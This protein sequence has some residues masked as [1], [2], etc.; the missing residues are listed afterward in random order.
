MSAP[1]PAKGPPQRVALDGRYARLE[2]LRRTHADDLFAA[3]SV[4]D[5]AQR[6]AYLPVDPPVSI[7]TLRAWIAGQQGLS[8]PILFAVV[9]RASGRAGGW[10][11][12]MRVVPE[13]GVVEI[14]Y[15]YWGPKLARTRVA[16]E[17]L[18]LYARYVFDELGYRRFEWKCN[19]LNEP[20]KAAARR[21]GFQ[22]E[23]VF[24]QHMIVKG[25]NRDTA[26]FAML[27]GD[28][29]R[30]KAEFERW[31]APGNFD[32]DGLQKTPLRFAS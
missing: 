18:Y 27:D 32:A 13:H 16:T 21:F 14:G 11:Q 4:P 24:R 30:L 8:D 2:P 7:E 1:S 15:V 22:F 26:W 10:Q 25:E 28:W 19:T 5:V 12:L 3:A 17:A 31:L 29:P 6:F 23:G 20:S 9:D